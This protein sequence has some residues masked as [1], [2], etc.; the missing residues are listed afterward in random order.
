MYKVLAVI[1]VTLITGLASSHGAYAYGAIA[2][3]TNHGD[4]YGMTWNNPSQVLANADALLQC[5]R[6]AKSS[7]ACT[8]IG[9]VTKQCG[10]VAGT[11]ARPAMPASYFGATGPKLAT[12]KLNALMGCM[13]TGAKCR[14]VVSGCDT[15]RQ[16]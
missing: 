2:I 5:N 4:S 15:A 1:A 16:Q 13:K 12:A 9:L 14:V 7:S 3:G 11:E 10:A 6:R 8:I